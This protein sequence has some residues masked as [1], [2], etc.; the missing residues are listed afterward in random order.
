MWRKDSKV[1]PLRSLF[2]HV[3]LQWAHLDYIHV[4]KN[5]A[6]LISCKEQRPVLGHFRYVSAIVYICWSRWLGI[7]RKLEAC[8]LREVNLTFLRYPAKC[9]FHLG[10]WPYV[11]GYKCLGLRRWI[12]L[13][14]YCSLVQLSWMPLVG[15]WFCSVS[16]FFWRRSPTSL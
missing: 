10:I 3:N 4:L 8:S 11:D 7:N 12:G 16:P 15:L 2:C 5:I 9:S 13:I 6:L 1:C 14:C